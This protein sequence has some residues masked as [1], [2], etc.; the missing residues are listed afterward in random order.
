MIFNLVAEG[1]MEEIVAA[2]LLPFCEHGLG[3]VYGKRGCSYIK[4]KATHFCNLATS[5]TGVLV[6]TDFRDAKVSCVVEALDLYVYNKLPQPPKNFI[7]RFAI[8]ELES[9][10][11]ADRKSIA[12]FL[13]IN[14][15]NVPI[16]PDDESMP[17][18]TLINLARKSTRKIIREGL[19]PPPGHI[20]D[21]GPL[22][23]S[24]LSDFIL[25][26]WN[27]DT[28]C[29]HSPSLNRCVQRLREI[30]NG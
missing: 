28:A 30:K 19:A 26:F 7:C 9:W 20:A 29:C 25:N 27:I 10:L 4:E 21:V 1:H 23:I 5:D 14:E 17:K 3:T 15:S 13:K 2:Q 12:K 24:L 18:R 11:L 8:N 6:L 22:Y 16:N